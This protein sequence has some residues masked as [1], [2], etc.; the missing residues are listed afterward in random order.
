MKYPCPYRVKYFHSI[1][2]SLRNQVEC[3]MDQD[4]PEEK[5]RR[6]I[7]K[8]VSS[9]DD[10]IEED[11]QVVFV[12]QAEDLDTLDIEDDDFVIYLSIKMKLNNVIT[13]EINEP[14][15]CNMKPTMNITN[16]KESHRLMEQ[17]NLNALESRN[18]SLSRKESPPKKY[19]PKKQKANILKEPKIEAKR[20]TYEASDTLSSTSTDSDDLDLDFTS[21]R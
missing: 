15:T 4:Q 10:L 13:P 11:A 12:R 5:I 1:D 20:Y 6:H 19:S 18:G 3:K 9:V 17:K 7:E 8:T 14:E 2:L 16:C 21:L